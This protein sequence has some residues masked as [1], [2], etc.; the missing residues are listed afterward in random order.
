METRKLWPW[1]YDIMIECWK[2]AGLHYK[3]DGRDSRDEVSRQMADE[4]HIGFFGIFDD[5]ELVATVVA[6]HDTRK[7]W[8]NRLAVV[9]Q[10]R[11]KGLGKRL[12]A[13][14]ERW[15]EKQGLGIFCLQIEE[16]NPESKGLFESLDYERFEGIAYYTK[17]LD[18]KI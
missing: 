18:Q 5:S 16:P 6:S 2:R 15:F 12:V 11:R 4:N 8:I 1:D 10:Y 7:G 13:E 3:P 17:R 14:C 9:P